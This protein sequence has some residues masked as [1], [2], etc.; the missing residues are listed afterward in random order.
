[1]KR[2]AILLLVAV[3]AMPLAAQTLS[4][5][6]AD[7]LKYA[8]KLEKSLENPK[9]A[10]TSEPWFKLSQAYFDIYSSPSADV[11][12]NAQQ[13]EV[14]LLTK[15]KQFTTEERVVGDKTFY[16]D[17]YDNKDLYY[18]A[19]GVLQFW[20]VKKPLQDDALEKS[21]EAL[22]K[23]YKL[24]EYNYKTKKYIELAEK[25]HTEYHNTGLFY[26]MAGDK[27]KAE[28]FFEKAYNSTENDILNRTDTIGVYYAGLMARDNGKADKALELFKKDLAAGYAANGEINAAMAEIYREKGEMENYKDILEK[29]FAAF[30]QNQQIL[31]GLINYNLDT[32][33]DS[34]RLFEL[35]HQAQENEPNNAS[36]WYVEGDINKKLGNK[37]AAL[38]LFQKSYDI[39]NKYIFG[40]VNKGI[41]YYEEA[42][43]YQ[44]KANLEMDD[45]K[46][47]ALLG[48]V[49]NS[50][51][52]AIEPFEKSYELAAGDPELQVAIAEYLKSIYFRFRNDSDEYMAQYEKYNS[53]FKQATE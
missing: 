17:V 36:L 22:K 49:N 33:G 18:D 5:K 42:L 11:Y 44:D 21:L 14:R 39:D 16:V 2:I 52:K 23:S 43:E 25:I 19:N 24:D 40:I 8:A 47:E 30:P 53:I 34:S 37:E 32:N 20:L 41:M 1:M 7:L 50:L 12:P 3:M 10:G 6:E 35:I 45:A 48:E 31:V 4:K 38:E 46:Y 9:K 28:E 29:G 13:F 15:G 26:Y 51:K 27:V